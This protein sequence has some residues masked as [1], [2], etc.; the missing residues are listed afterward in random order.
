MLP[1]CDMFKEIIFTPRL[2]AFNE[3]F[4]P[5][6]G[7]SKKHNIGPTAVLWHEA[8]RGRSKEDIISTFYAFFFAQLETRNTLFCGSITV[9]H[10]TK[11]G[12]CIRFLYI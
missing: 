6:A 12:V 1:R 7:C 9:L 3:S 2:I 4:V 5:T 11:T 10:K 8:I